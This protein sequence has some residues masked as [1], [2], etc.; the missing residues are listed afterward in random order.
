MSYFKVYV[1]YYIQ[2]SEKSLC[3]RYWWPSTYIALGYHQSWWC[4]LGGASHECQ[5]I[6][7][8]CFYQTRSAWSMDQGSTRKRFAVHNFARAVTKFC[9]MWEG[10][11]LPHD[12]KFGNCRG[13]IVDMRVIFI[14]SL[15]HGSGWSRLIKAEPGVIRKL[16]AVEPHLNTVCHNMILQ[17]AWQWKMT[18]KRWY[19]HFLTLVGD[20]SRPQDKKSYQI[21]K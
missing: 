1:N 8:L 2:R 19:E 4:R 10:L 14:W 20:L 13:E 3:G 9:V 7:W 5:N 6:T 18:M 12:T 21:L 16:C 11:S 15:I 17:L